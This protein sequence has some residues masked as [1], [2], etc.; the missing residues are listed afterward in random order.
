MSGSVESGRPTP[1]AHA[2]E[3][4]RAEPLPQRLQAVV[5]GQPAADAAADVAERQ[6]DLVVEDEHAVE[7]E[8]QRAARGAGRAAG[9]VHVGLRPEHRDARAAGAGAA[10]GEQAGVALLGLGQLP[11]AGELVGDLEADVVRRAR[12][13]VARVAEPD[14]QPVDRG[15]RR[16][17]RRPSRRRTARALLGVC[18][19]PALGRRVA[20]ASV[21]ALAL[22]ASPGALAD[23]L[24]LL[25]DRLLLGSMSTRGGM[26][27]AM[28]VSSRS[29]RSVT[30][31]GAVTA[32]S[33]TV[34]LIVHVRDVVLDRLGDV[35][36]ERLDVEL[37]RDLLEHA[38][39]DRRRAP[40]RRR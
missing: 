24:G 4:G 31:S 35:A 1:I 34:S 22:G 26:S 27:V 18:A 2:G 10:L 20:P 19:S 37:A 13:A 38:A 21:V 33:V 6:V 7:V 12:V 32:D 25:L 29:S 3:V 39:L 23:E 11:A 17:T 14:D 40:P 9:L 15:L 5:A 28:T 30:P 16:R 8:V 36:R